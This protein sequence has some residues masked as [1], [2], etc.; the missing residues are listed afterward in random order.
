ME[1]QSGLKGFIDYLNGI[2]QASGRRV[3][4]V[5]HNA[6]SFDCPVLF[7]S[8]ERHG[9]MET[10]GE[11][12]LLFVDSLKIIAQEVKN[13]QGVLSSCSSKS[14]GVVY[15]H[16]F[17]EKFEA[18]DAAE[19]TEALFRILMRIGMDQSKAD[20]HGIA[21]LCM[22]RRIQRSERIPCVKTTYD[23]LPITY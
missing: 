20:S 21:L 10:F 18:H 1:Q 11:I 14:L 16:L 17:E 8:L 15:E 23:R 2:E 3:V 9:L 6:F 12:K 5:A 13:A 4:L 7:K 22:T 19:D